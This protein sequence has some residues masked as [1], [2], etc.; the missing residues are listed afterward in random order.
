M[1]PSF[2]DV[3]LLLFLCDAS[4]KRDGGAAVGERVSTRG[5]ADTKHSAPALC[6]EITPHTTRRLNDVIIKC[7]H[8]Y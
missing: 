5:Q 7:V 3:F 1:N 4:V 2:I 6:A 8:F